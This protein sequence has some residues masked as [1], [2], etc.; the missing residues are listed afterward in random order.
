M[1]LIFFLLLACLAFAQESADSIENSYSFGEDALN[2]DQFSP[3]PT[4]MVELK[5]DRSWLRDSLTSNNSLTKS[6]TIKFKRNSE[7]FIDSELFYV[8]IG[9]AVALGA[10]AAYFKLESDDYYQ[11]YLITNDQSLKKKTDRYDLYS[12]I[13]LGAMEIN[14]GILIYKFLTD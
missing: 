6:S 9:S 13:A 10:A 8:I 11:K 14:I 3:L 2:Y 4:S 12:G 7:N 5:M 1:K